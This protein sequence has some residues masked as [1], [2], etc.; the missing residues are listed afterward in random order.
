MSTQGVRAPGRPRGYDETAVLESALQ[1]FWRHGF[2]ETSMAQIREVTGLS[3]ASLGYAFGSKQ[4]LFER[5]VDHYTATFGSVTEAAMDETLEPRDAL[6]QALRQSLQM[7][8]DPSHPS[9]CLL[10]LSSPLASESSD[11]ARRIVAAQRDRVRARIRS[12]IDRGAATGVLRS[13][14]DAAGMVAMFHAFLIGLS[15]EICD[16]ASRDALDRAISSIMSAW[17]AAAR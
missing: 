12:A 6:E 9:G 17:D 10:A 15:T 7:Q 8:T 4:D 1:L 14:V 11:G 13:D 5:V 3:N 16:G 2:A